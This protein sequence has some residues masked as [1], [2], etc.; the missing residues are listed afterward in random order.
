MKKLLVSFF[1]VVFY[2]ADFSQESYNCYPTHW[3]AGMKW[4]KLQI[5]VHGKNVADNFPMIKMGPEG[6]KL[7][8]GVR[9]MKINRV[10]NP[11]YIFLD[12]TIDASAKPGKF[13]FHFVK[14]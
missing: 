9:L 8:T 5:M 3:W 14:I 6:I 12:I 7:A 4:N 1:A 2:V 10:E 11:N 13:N